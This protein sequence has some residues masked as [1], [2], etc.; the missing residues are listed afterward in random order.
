[1][2]GLFVGSDRIQWSYSILLKDIRAQGEQDVAVSD[3]CGE[4]S[5]EVRR[6]KC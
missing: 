2:A 6:N 1:M 4:H 3:A 5:M